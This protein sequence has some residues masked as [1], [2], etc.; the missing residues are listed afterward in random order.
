[1]KALSIRQPW[2]WLVVNGYK[3]IEN[4]PRPLK[5]RGRI[6]VHAGKKFDLEGYR[7]VRANFPD[8]QMPRLEEFQ[9]GGFVGSVEITDCVAQSESRWFFGPYGYVLE[10]AETMPFAPYKGQLGLFTVRSCE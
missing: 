2:A 3:P 4:R 1:M 10:N 8:I 7:F 9:L 5:Y 6:L